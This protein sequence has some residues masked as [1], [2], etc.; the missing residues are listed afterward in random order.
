VTEIENILEANFEDLH[1]TYFIRCDAARVAR[2]LTKLITAK[3]KK[4]LETLLRDYNK[5]GVFD[6]VEIKNRAGADALLSC[7]GVLE[8]AAQIGFVDLSKEDAFLSQ[9]R[10]ILNDP[11]VKSYFQKFYKIR[12]PE[13]FRRRLNGKPLQCDLNGKGHR[14]FQ[15]FLSIDLQFRDQLDDGEL[16]RMLDGFWIGGYSFEDL[17]ELIS[18][19][20]DFIERLMA[21]DKSRSPLTLAAKQLGSFLKFCESFKSLLDNTTEFPLLQSLFWHHYGY[22]FGIIGDELKEGLGEALE[23]FLEWDTSVVETDEVATAQREIR[24]YVSSCMNGISKLTSGGYGRD[25]NR[26]LASK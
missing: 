13:L 19:P 3:K 9:A 1:K 22:W 14:Q 6:A 4:M 26:L 25:I 16:L 12:L 2:L 5:R 11:P 24:E 8:I 7:Y 21:S 23:E 10:R 17:V 15:A 20:R 18:E